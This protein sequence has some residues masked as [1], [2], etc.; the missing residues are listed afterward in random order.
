MS[1][2]RAEQWSLSFEIV[3]VKYDFLV[4]SS[5]LRFLEKHL[6]NALLVLSVLAIVSTVIVLASRVGEASDPVLQHLLLPVTAK[7]AYRLIWVFQPEDCGASQEA[8]DVL[9]ESYAQ[10]KS[11]L[12]VLGAENI[13]DLHDVRKAY[14]VRIPIMRV[15]PA[16]LAR[17]LAHLGY[18]ATPVVMIV[19]A[20]G[21]IR[22]AAPGAEATEL[23]TRWLSQMP[24]VFNAM[25]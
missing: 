6:A 10:R 8:L 23:A 25:R 18:H 4:K 13:S 20:A 15:D 21:Q 7:P 11:V 22:E 24:G 2:F 3:D 19:D 17:F 5:S 9:N 12:G 14:D 16:T 1:R